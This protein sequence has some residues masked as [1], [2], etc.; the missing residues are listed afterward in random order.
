MLLIKRIRYNEQKLPFHFRNDTTNQVWILYANEL[1]DTKKAGFSYAKESPAF[2]LLRDQLPIL[3][4]YL[5]FDSRS[6]FRNTSIDNRLLAH[7]QQIKN[8]H[9]KYSFSGTYIYLYMPPRE[10]IARMY[11]INSL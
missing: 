5:Q 7:N 4:S 11:M 3:L 9:K 2:I 10:S 8:H 1:F 6:R